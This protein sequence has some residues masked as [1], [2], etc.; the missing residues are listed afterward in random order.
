MLDEELAIVCFVWPLMLT[1]YLFASYTEIGHVMGVITL[2]K[3]LGHLLCK[4]AREIFETNP[5]SLDSL[6]DGW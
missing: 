2:S 5:Y 4:S 3:D 1:G 6:D